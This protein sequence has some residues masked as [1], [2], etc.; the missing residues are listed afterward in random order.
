[1]EKSE[2]IWLATVAIGKGYDSETMAYS[3][4]LYGREEDID[5][6]WPFM[7][8]CSAIGTIAFKE[9]YKEFKLYP[10]I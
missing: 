2:A 9:K 4:Y 1:M 6:V 7:E 3:D 8:E 5:I 10:G